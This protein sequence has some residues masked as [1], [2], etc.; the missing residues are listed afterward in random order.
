MTLRAKGQLTLPVEIPKAS[1]LV[2]GVLLDA[3]LTEEGILVRPK[4]IIDATQ[5]WLWSP[6]WQDGE[7]E[8]D[9]D[10]SAGRIEIFDLGDEFLAALRRGAK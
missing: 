1:H 8:A 4:K 7:H 10:L 9:N 3:E 5:S 2:D 6:E